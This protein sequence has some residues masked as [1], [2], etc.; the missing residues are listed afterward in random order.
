MRNEINRL[1]RWER[2]RHTEPVMLQK[3]LLLLIEP[4]DLGALRFARGSVFG[5]VRLRH[6]KAPKV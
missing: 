3:R 1:T 4:P 2:F 6:H 5:G